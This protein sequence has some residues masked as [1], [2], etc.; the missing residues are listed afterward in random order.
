MLNEEGSG[1][2]DSETNAELV[3]EMKEND[4]KVDDEN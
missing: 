3:S 2:S 1:K 4:V